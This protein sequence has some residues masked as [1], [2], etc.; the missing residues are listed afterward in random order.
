MND[1]LY[2]VQ[3]WDNELTN[4]YW[5][6]VNKSIDKYKEVYEKYISQRTKII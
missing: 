1:E 4:Y 2:L 6:D 5:I 3:E